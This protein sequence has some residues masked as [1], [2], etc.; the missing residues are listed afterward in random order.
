MAAKKQTAKRTSKVPSDETRDQKF[1]RLTNQRM[2]KVLKSISLIG[3]LAS[4]PHNPDN[5]AKIVAALKVAVDG[6]ERSFSNTKEAK[7]SFSL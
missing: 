2:P 7:Q 6:V 1:I 4:Y 5:A 3:N